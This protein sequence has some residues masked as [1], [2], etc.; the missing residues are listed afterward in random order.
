M[1]DIDLT[2]LRE[3]SPEPA[4]YTPVRRFPT[5]A[6]DLTVIAGERE[7]AGTL[8]LEFRRFAGDLAQSVEYVREY[9]LPEGKKSVTFRI[10]LSDPSRTLSEEDILA[11]RLRIIAGIQGEGYEMRV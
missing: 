8:Q 6:F 3:L 10:T 7:L 5:S 1:L 9:G 2:L 4:R 11:V